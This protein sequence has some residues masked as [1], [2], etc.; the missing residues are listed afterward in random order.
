[1]LDVLAENRDMLALITQPVPRGLVA[2]HAGPYVTVYVPLPHC[3]GG[4][5]T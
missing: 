2:A 3:S 4:T 1:M 5:V